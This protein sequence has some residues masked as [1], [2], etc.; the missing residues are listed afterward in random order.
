MIAAPSPVSEDGDIRLHVKAGISIPLEFV[1]ENGDPRDMT[2][3]PV[4]IEIEDGTRSALSATNDSHIL[5]L[6]LN[7][8]SFSSY[9][10]KSLKFVVLDEGVTPKDEIWSG[11]IIITGWG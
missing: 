6:V 10:G 4:F 2:G 3:N 8:S 9:V 7:G 5:A 11:K 1:D